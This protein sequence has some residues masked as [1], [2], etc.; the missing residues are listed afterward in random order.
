LD[1][2][3]LRAVLAAARGARDTEHACV[4]ILARPSGETSGSGR[5]AGWLA[6]RGVLGLLDLLLTPA[7]GRATRGQ[8]RGHRQQLAARYDRLAVD[9]ALQPSWQVQIRYAAAVDLPHRGDTPDAN[10]TPDA[11]N[12]ADLTDAAQQRLAGRAHAIATAFGAYTNG[13]NALRR[14]R[15]PRPAAALAGRR[16]RRGDRLGCDELAALAHLPIDASVPELDRAPAKPVAPPAA[17]T[18]GGRGMISLG[19]GPDGRAVTLSV[20]DSRHHMQVIGKTGSGKSTQLGN[21]TLG[22]A[23]AS[24][25]VGLVDPKGDDVDYVLQRLPDHAAGKV[26]LIDPAQPHGPAINPLDTDDLDLAVDQI[27]G[28]FTRVFPKAWGP[29]ADDCLRSACLTLGRFYG[30]SLAHVTPLLTNRGTR[31]RL[32]ADLDDP[33]GLGGFWTWFDNM[34]PALQAQVISPVISRLRA[35][36][37][38]PFVRDTLCAPASSLDLRHTIDH[39]GIILA[40]LPKGVL[41]EDTCR[42]LGSLLVAQIWQAATGRAAVPE[43]QR[44]DTALIIDEAQNFLT[45]PRALDEMLAEARGYRLSLTLAHQHLAQLPREMQL[46][47]SA[48]ARNKII[49]GVS[50]EDAHVLARHTEPHLDEHDLAHPDRFTAATKL[51]ADGAETPAFTLHPHPPS[52]PSSDAQAIREA[53]AERAKAAA[54]AARVRHE[55]RIRH[56]SRR[57][58][59]RRA[60]PQGV[61]TD[62]SKGAAGDER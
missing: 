12:N 3:P 28:I 35:L 17:A 22:H 20:A 59:A 13:H 39:G 44:P 36:L 49:F 37:L 52:E 2:D 30:T 51:V 4:Q 21:L 23:R 57:H 46:G 48:N 16:L 32:T 56:A 15:L 31:A 8:H 33:A 26:V 54:E 27:C 45:L 47:L 10:T 42:L 62:T 38:R 5:G 34:N 40:R 18:T 29:R 43:Q 9:K 58:G 55:K 61:F 50:P 7:G 25:A 11:D 24:R 41:G 60:L 1:P 6:A 14:R 19:R 53:A